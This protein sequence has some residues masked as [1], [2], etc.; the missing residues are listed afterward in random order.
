[1]DDFIICSDCQSR[2]SLSDALFH[3]PEANAILGDHAALWDF[4]IG[5]DLFTL[6]F[7]FLYTRDF[8]SD[9]DCEIA[10]TQ[11]IFNVMVNKKLDH[12]YLTLR[13]VQY[14]GLREFAY[15]YSGSCKNINDQNIFLDLDLCDP[16]RQMFSPELMMQIL[17]D[18]TLAPNFLGLDSYDY[19]GEAVQNGFVT[20]NGNYLAWKTGLNQIFSSTLISLITESDNGDYDRVTVFTEK[21]IYAL[22]GLTIPI[23]PGGYKHAEM[24]ER[25]GFDVFPDLIDHSYQNEPTMFMRCWRAFKDNLDLLNHDLSTAKK[26]RDDIMSRLV[27]NRDYLLSEQL[28]NWYHE[29]MSSW[30]S[31]IREAVFKR[32][33]QLGT[34]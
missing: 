30:P 4:E 11:K 22:L 28:Q 3:A 18:V 26:I 2:A 1:M 10:N 9:H 24:F 23:W 34:R 27:R 20:Y 17:G 32:F 29:Q 21:T 16:K 5:V 6:P 14:F 12:R 7:F 33:K 25:M 19:L 31:G 15:T 8:F 13:L